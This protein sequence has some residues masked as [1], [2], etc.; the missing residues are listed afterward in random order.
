MMDHIRSVAGGFPEQHHKHGTH[1]RVESGRRYRYWSVKFAPVARP[2][3]A[4]RARCSP[5]I[6]HTAGCSTTRAAAAPVT[7][8]FPAN[9]HTR[10][11]TVM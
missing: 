4:V 8:G 7:A 6:T 2:A 3:S 1:T 11:V 9:S 10:V 5:H